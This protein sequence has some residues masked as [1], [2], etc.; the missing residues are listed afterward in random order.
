[1]IHDI[2]TDV[3][4]RPQAY[5]YATIF[6]NI[7]ANR[8]YN[9]GKSTFKCKAAHIVM[10]LLS[11][12]RINDHIYHHT[13]ACGKGFSASSSASDRDWVGAGN[14]LKSLKVRYFTLFNLKD[15]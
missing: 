3:K 1:M 13:S 9:K 15:L 10:L 6:I 7:T 2:Y 4:I 14:N 8:Y 12:N 11:K 5:R